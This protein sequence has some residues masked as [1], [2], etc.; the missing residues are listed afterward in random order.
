MNFFEIREKTRLLAIKSLMI[1]FKGVGFP[2][3]V[4]LHAEFFSVR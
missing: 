4:I 2:K 1:S 3:D